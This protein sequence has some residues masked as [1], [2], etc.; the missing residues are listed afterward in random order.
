M[1]VC[2]WPAAAAGQAPFPDRNDTVDRRS[3]TEIGVAALVA[4]GCAVFW[5]QA[6]KLPP[7]SFEPLGSGPVPMYTAAVI[8]LCCLIVTGRALMTILRAP[9]LFR[10]LS[11]EFPNRP[12]MGGILMLGSSVVYV[13]LLHLQAASFGVI[14][15]VF[16]AVLIWAME[17]FRLRKAPLALIF[18]AIFAFGAEY[19]FTNVFVVDLPT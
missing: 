14:T 1:T 8:I 4:S 6:D 16:L 19:V 9:S 10:I 3:F 13:G 2:A 5:F 11:E 7:G 12:R 15:F 18:A 17:A